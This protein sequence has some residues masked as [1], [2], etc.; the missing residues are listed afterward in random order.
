MAPSRSDLAPSPAALMPGLT[1]LTLYLPSP[2][3]HP[4]RFLLVPLPPAGILATPSACLEVA[5]G[6]GWAAPQNVASSQE[7]VTP[8]LPQG[9]F[10]SAEPAWGGGVGG[11]EGAWPLLWLCLTQGARGS[12]GADPLAHGECVCF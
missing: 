12:W 6:L 4:P 10:L 8:L 11:A 2:P 9:R 7:S 1:A 5:A 3:T